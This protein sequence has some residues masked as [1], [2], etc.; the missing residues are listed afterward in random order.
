MGQKVHPYGFRLGVTKN[1][2]SR[3]F[4][5]QDYAKLLHE[6]LKLKESLRERLKA[7]GVSP[8]NFGGPL[9]SGGVSD[10]RCH[11][12]RRRAEIQEQTGHKSLKVLRTY[13]REGSLFRNN[14]AKKAG[15]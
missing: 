6:D 14:A 7:A 2:R 9:A 5:T 15:L 13:I 4:A 12:G 10:G 1:W 8:G 11:G 3:W